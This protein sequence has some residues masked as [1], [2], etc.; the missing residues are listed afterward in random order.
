MDLENR[1]WQV[2]EEGLDDF[3][4]H[5]HIPWT[6]LWLIYDMITLLAAT[7]YDDDDDDD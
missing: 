1:R 3:L 2:K 4:E 7:V 5:F 6:N